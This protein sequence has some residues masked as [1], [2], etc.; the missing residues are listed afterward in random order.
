MPIESL[1]FV[2]NKNL[3]FTNQILCQF[4]KINSWKLF[5]PVYVS[6]KVKSI[7]EISLSDLMARIGTVLVIYINIK[8]LPA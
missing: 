8:D 7:Q 4:Q 5:V 1:R 6:L 3:G 2:N